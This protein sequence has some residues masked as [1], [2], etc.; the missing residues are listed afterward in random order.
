ML[1]DADLSRGFRKNALIANQ[2]SFQPSMDVNGM[3]KARNSFMTESET[4][5]FHAP[6]PKTLEPCDRRALKWSRSN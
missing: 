6:R 4:W 1:Q 2:K 5:P 3:S